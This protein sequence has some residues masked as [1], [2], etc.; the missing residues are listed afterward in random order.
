V[1]GRSQCSP[2]EAKPSGDLRQRN[3]REGAFQPSF[4][5]LPFYVGIAAQDLDPAEVPDV[6][7]I[8]PRLGNWI[9]L[10]LTHISCTTRRF[11][12]RSSIIKLAENLLAFANFEYI[13]QDPADALGGP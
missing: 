13:C 10:G 12:C 9:P 7:R 8:G 11:N 3:R 1:R 2:S 6:V 5:R 4:V